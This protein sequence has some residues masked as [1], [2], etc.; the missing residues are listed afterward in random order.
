VQRASLFFIAACIS[1]SAMDQQSEMVERAWNLLKAGL[2]DTSAIQRAEAAHAL[3]L[4]HTQ[5]TVEMAEKALADPEK[6]VRSEAAVALGQMKAQEALPKLHE[7]LNDKEIQVVLAC[8][9]SMYQLKDPAAFDVYYTILTGERRSH[10]GLVAGQLDT[11]KDRKQVEKLAFETG[12]GFVP[13]GGGAWQAV[14]TVR[15][16]DSSPVRAMAAQRLAEDKDPGTTKVLENSLT[17]KKPRVREAAITALAQRGDPESA[18][19]LE[20]LL[21]DNNSAVRYEA[22]AAIISLSE[23]KS[24][25][26]SKGRSRNKRN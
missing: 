24:H 21:G 17:D 23:P 13:F 11:L 6:Q 19:S 15:H 22:A 4:A 18:S 2:S 25:S 1:A 10:E 5:L 26:E 3:G 8:T 12:I 9:N 7:C 14:K 20:A 16:D